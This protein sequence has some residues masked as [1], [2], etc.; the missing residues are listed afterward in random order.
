MPFFFLTWTKVNSEV[1]VDTFE[2][3][4]GPETHGIFVCVF[5]LRNSQYK[6]L[7]TE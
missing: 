2:V 6:I 4:S 3:E 7:F 5:Q 1:N